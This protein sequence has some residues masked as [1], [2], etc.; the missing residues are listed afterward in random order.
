M[1]N[2]SPIAH[3]QIIQTYMGN[4]LVPIVEID[5]YFSEKYIIDYI[6]NIC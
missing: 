3:I 4:I 5:A 1:I 2:L 6:P